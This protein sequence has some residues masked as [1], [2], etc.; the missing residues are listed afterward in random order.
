MTFDEVKKKY[1]IGSYDSVR[2]KYG[3]R[4]DEEKFY[5]EVSNEVQT[6]A[7]D[8]QNFWMNG[9]AIGTSDYSNLTIS[10]AKLD[11]RLKNLQKEY[12]GN[13]QATN[14]FAQLSDALTGMRNQEYDLHKANNYKKLFSE[15]QGVASTLDSY[16]TKVNNGE[17][18]SADDLSA[19]R[20]ASEEYSRIGDQLFTEEFGYTPEEIQGYKNSRSASSNLADSAYGIYR[21]YA[22][23]EAYNLERAWN[24]EHGT[25]GARQ[26]WNNDMLRKKERLGANMRREIDEAMQRGQSEMV[27]SIMDKYGAKIEA[28]DAELGKYERGEE[29]EYGL[30]Y[31]NKTLDEYY[32]LMGN[33]DFYI[34]SQRKSEA[35]NAPREDVL[36]VYNDLKAG[37]SGNADIW[38]AGTSN[39]W[40]SL[41]SDEVQLYYYIGNT[42]G[43]DKAE[44][45]LNNIVRTL[46][47]RATE[48]AKEEW[49]LAYDEAN[50]FGKAWMNIKTVPAN[51]LSGVI[52][53]IENVAS[54][55]GGRDIDPY[56]SGQRGMHYSNTV[57]SATESDL[58]ALTGDASLLGISLGDFYQAVMS[59]ADSMVSMALFGG[60]GGSVA[61]GMGAAQN[62]AYDLYKK[63]ASA[64]QILIGSLAAGAAEIAFEKIAFGKLKELD[65]VSGFGGWLKNMAVQGVNEFI[66][67][68]ETEIANII[69]DHFVMGT[70]SEVT[71][72]LEKNNGDWGQTGIDLLKQVYE[73]GVAGFIG[74]FGA[75]GVQSAKSQVR[76]NA[77]NRTIGKEIIKTGGV[78]TLKG[79]TAEGASS[80]RID[81]LSNKVTDVDSRSNARNVGQL[82]GEVTRS[83]AKKNA[84]ANAA[85]VAKALQ[86]GGISEKDASRLA[87]AIIAQQNGTATDR[88]ND[89]VDQ[90][91]ENDTV[92]KVMRDIVLN[93]ESSVGQRS[94]SIREFNDAVS[95]VKGLN[96]ALD[97]ADM[98]IVTGKL[99]DGGIETDKVNNVAAAL[100]A[101]HSGVATKEQKQ[102]LEE[103]KG[104]EAVANANQYLQDAAE[105][106]LTVDTYK[107]MLDRDGVVTGAEESAEYEELDAAAMTE[108]FTKAGIPAAT[109]QQLAESY[110]AESGVVSGAFAEDVRLAF[111]YGKLNFKEGLQNL[112][113]SES[114]A[115]EIF[116]MGAESVKVASTKLESTR[117]IIKDSNANKPIY[118]DNFTYN[119]HQLNPTQRA[120][121][122]AIQMINKLSNL[123]VH[124]YKSYKRDGKFY[125]TIN[126]EE[127]VAPNGYFTNGNQIHIDLN[128]GQVGEGTMLYTL[129]H[130]IGHYIAKWNAADFKAIS[131]F[132]FEHYAASTPVAELIEAKKEVVRK[133][134]KMDKK[135][136]P[137][138]AQL[139]QEAQEELVCDML[140]KVLADQHAYDVLMELKQKDLR[141][142]RKLGRAIK[143]ILQRLGKAIGVYQDQEPAA[144]YAASTKNFGEKAFR[145]LQELYV[146]A[147]EQ[148]DANYLES[149]TPGEEGTVFSEDGDP[150]AHATEDGTV[151]LSMRTYEEEGRKA[152][153][154]YLKKCVKNK[155][156]TDDEMQ[157]MMNGI[158][159]IYKT[160][161]EFKD[162]YAPFSTWSDASVVRDT[163]GKPV[164]SVVTPNGDYKM[165]L[166]F[167]LV[168]KKRRTLDAVFNEMARRGI[169]D[170]FELGQ[171]SVVK[172]NE[173]IRKYGLET[174]CALC[175]V[176]AKR[177]RQAS[178]AD[179]FVRLYNELVESLVPEDQRGNIE[180]FN[181]GG[182]DTIGKV[183]NGIHTWDKSKLDFTHLDNVMKNYEE[184]TVE[185]KA[186]KYIKSHAEGRKL[187]LR[188]DFMSSKG[189]DAV[190][191]QNP[192]VLKL[193]NSKKGTGGPKAA[194]GD[195]QYMNEIIEKARFWT[196]E[197]A[198]AVGGIR[199][200]SFSDYVPRMV[201]DYVQMV[202]DMAATKLPAHAYTKEA[203]FAKQFGLT[204]IK[205]NMSLIPAIAK[206]GIA[207][208]LDADGNYVWAGESFDFETAKQI[209]N[210][211]GYTENCGTIC[212]GVSYQHIL[213]LLSDPDIRMVI[214]YHKSGLNPIVAHMNQ[215][216]EFTDYTSLKTNPGG[217]QNTMNKNGSKVEVDFNFNKV[218]RETGDPKKT[219]RQYLDWCAEHEYTPRFAE[220]A[221]HENYYK[222]IED[223]TLYDK[224]GKYVPQRAVKAT[225][226][227][228]GNA[229]G[230]MKGLIQ[231]GLQ[232]DAVI[233]GKR[234]KNL[235]A[236]VNEIQQT[237]PKTE[238]E[239]SEEEVT[240]A[241]RD[242]EDGTVYSERD[243]V[244]YDRT[245]ILKESKV[246]EYLE[247]YA[248]VS[249]PKYAQAYITYMRPRTFLKL[250]TDD[251]LERIHISEQAGEL[252]E[253][254]LSNS[255]PG[256]YL[257]IDH[258]TGK[259]IGHEGRHRMAAME[260]AHINL[261]PVLLLDD[262]NKKTKTDIGQMYLHGQFDETE[263]GVVKDIIP[264]SY[265]NRDRIIKKFATQSTTQRIGE[266]Y[267][268][269]KTLRFQER[270]EGIASNR[271][272]LAGAL[273]TV[274]K[275]DT[276][277]KNLANYKKN[278]EMLNAEEEKL[279]GLQKELH[280]LMFAK[281][282]RN[283]QKMAE[284]REEIAK[285][286]NRINTYDGRL[287]RME[288][289][290]PLRNLLTRE[291]RKGYK[292]ASAEAVEKINEIRE[293]L[294]TKQMREKVMRVVKELDSMLK[295]DS[296]KRHVPDSLKK[297]VA[298]ALDILNLDTTN[299]DERVAMYRKW[300]AEETDPD[301]IDAYQVS[302]ENIIRAGEKMGE[303]LSQLHT[304]YQAIMT[305]EDKDI[306]AGYDPG[307]ALA[308]QEL[309]ETIGTTPINKLSIEQLEDVYNVYM[310][311][312]TR[313]RDANKSLIESIKENIK[314]R[315]LATINEVRA[316]GGVH[317]DRVSMLDGFKRFGWNNLKPVYA[318]EEIGS[319]TLT[320]AFNNVR[321]GEDT[322]ALDVTAARAYFLRL[323]KEYG[324]D[325]W[326]MD[327][328]YTFEAIDGQKFELTLEQM[329]SLYAYSKR[330]QADEHLRLGG[331]VFDSNIE[332]K[333]EKVKDEK[334]GEVVKKTV[335]KY[336][337]NTARSHQIGLD[338]MQ[339][340]VETV[341][342]I[343]GVKDFVDGMQ[344]YLSTTMGAK[345]NEVTMKMYGIKLFKEE[346]YFPLKSAKQ[347]LFEQNQV[348]GEV[349]IKNS[350]F[351]NKLVAGANNPIILSNFM[352][353]WCQ[354]VNDMSMYHAFTLPLEDFNRIFN[355]GSYGKEGVDSESVKGTIQDAYGPAAV[356]YIKQLI[357]DLNGG[358]VSDPREVTGQKL[359]GKWKKAKVMASL[360]VVIQQP[361]SIA[362][363]FAMVDPKYFVGKKTGM[364]EAESW[365]EL[366]KYAPVA[367]I[368]EMGYFDT[369]MGLGVKDFIQQKEYEGFKDKAKGVVT[370]SNYRD[371]VLGKAPAKADE[372]TWVAIWN[373]VKRETAGRHPD[374]KPGTEEY[375]KAAGERFTEVITKTQVY[376][377]VLARSANMR[378]KGTFMNMATAFLAEPTTTINMAID[379]IVKWN[380]GEKKLA[381][382][383]LR[384]V[385]VCNVINNMLSSLVY[386]MRDDDEEETFIE[387]YMQSLV[388]GLIDDMNPMTYFPWL[389][390]VWSIL[391][392]YDVN[393]SDMSLISDAFNAGK[394]LIR[395]Y[396]R[397]ENLFRAW[398]EL[399][400]S[401]G[402]FLGVPV[403]NMIREG[404]AFVNTWDTWTKDWGARD[405]TWGSLGDAIG[406]ALKN[407]A[408]VYG[409]FA[410]DSKT[411]D[412]YDAVV[413]G[414][415]K[416]LDRF[417]GSYVDKDGNFDESKYNTALKQGLR[418]NDERIRE[419]AEARIDGDY[420][421]YNQLL[422]EIKNEGKF[423]HST[424]RDAIFAE[425]NDI[426]K[427]NGEGEKEKSK[428]EAGYETSFTNDDYFSAV[429]AGDT[430]SAKMI[431]KDL[432]DSK[433]SDG[434]LNHEAADSISTALAT[435]IGNRYMDGEIS[436]NQA[437]KLLTDNTDKGETEAKK[438]DFEMKYGFSWSNRARKYRT[439]KI[440]R[441]D[442]EKWV[443]DIDG[444]DR[445]EAK[446]YVDFL[447]LEMANPNTDITAADAESFF[448]HAQ[449]SGIDIDTYLEFK[450]KVSTIKGD[451]KKEQVLKY[452]HSLPLTVAQKDALYYAQGYAESNVKNTPWH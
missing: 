336:K 348:S 124:V 65:D 4:S 229:F 134:Y 12:A 271:E 5:D 309:A 41:G 39:N 331:F 38:A 30:S 416:Y 42:K 385:M 201:F 255:R 14:Y 125:T 146:M 334:T 177:F 347:F 392:G 16:S 253:E 226:P 322:W 219:V 370:D 317:D 259:V 109:A 224:D 241:D 10:G 390:D 85:D 440:S 139:E 231:E 269:S 67:E 217:C 29:N 230:S 108:S 91:A 133:S 378:S 433:L 326:D 171:K 3:I 185:Y 196:P 265:E 37:R 93:Q 358:A 261:V 289:S 25:V 412:L 448:E 79:M 137:G 110:D 90:F 304:G 337:K 168:C 2:G 208:G 315:S 408:P 228:E 27:F 36:G 396:D 181:F 127:R 295:E 179:S 155:R 302:L 447:D 129:S 384:A 451:D 156:L 212:V 245:A 121:M 247:D 288:V 427:D 207:P 362:R 364:T 221:W 15:F 395:A 184:G 71:Q 19:Y 339:K 160:C 161:K 372:I 374:L 63:G 164:F 354:H 102:L 410:S 393:R 442:L 387:K 319:K 254:R 50:F 60:V 446:A 281:G 188:G 92:H 66:E 276:E 1:G 227:K 280:D 389:K 218:L 143:L 49:Q 400:G 170:D 449:P 320:E 369:G 431:Y 152:L 422:T 204:G 94:K 98:R 260:N 73:A 405:T 210:A 163:R 186:A 46:N 379:A 329:M 239:I 298:G 135:P 61:L 99:R 128:A 151:Q 78:E 130:E 401:V 51:V 399:S 267:G 361:T 220:F 333:K 413:S 23:E 198:Y 251:F 346:N 291:R 191:T 203:L 236:I 278:I 363:A 213:K 356:S 101:V 296:K 283:S 328:T 365:E 192:D 262:S 76:T 417:K 169:I 330:A 256:I 324:Y 279:T 223:F 24:K 371:E 131:D 11:Q 242:L 368:K 299:T 323:S 359:M 306:R 193:Y 338:T 300:I 84:N 22:N 381:V 345:G 48:K 20:A 397:D 357:T 6:Y 195:V 352:D 290:T 62:K 87:N 83:I 180:R 28:I 183:E 176:D 292:K 321:K 104:N 383:I 428:S 158:D 391:Q 107:A 414:D 123:E 294:S 44:D 343:E 89:F 234:E 81:N 415:Q 115:N 82:Y 286:T 100:A 147:F 75:G 194:F 360:S 26:K 118:Y 444:A 418:D 258:D 272:L 74:G 335:L 21:G 452:I 437:I 376:D 243:Y 136:I 211:E 132:L 252:D 77:Y 425:E 205:I 57:R 47:K 386:A 402:N 55:A 438:W 106:K 244:A 157:E 148:A 149:L 86:E 445:A 275:D 142:F 232:E 43:W 80:R 366:K 240:Q 380:R 403:E 237:I 140:S 159:D 202:Y 96:K 69:S 40:D 450:G 426:R 54:W 222:L 209:Q 120:S 233:E 150:V 443:M 268:I 325:N 388:S 112:R 250:T 411:D 264:L 206:G 235:P 311:V 58:N 97:A 432:M 257:R 439:G 175:F 70:Q 297:A 429:L 105:D 199:V 310:S 35:G 394:G 31:G 277:R 8:W 7:N 355:Y 424:I 116:N 165:N 225:F 314:E 174:A 173:I 305:S 154:K 189:F 246:D 377:S 351:T 34:N 398:L 301:K 144:W 216:A 382:K 117:K 172:I 9:G 248:A 287:L 353:V 122:E 341:S 344:D 153:E 350:G 293:K 342:G 282:P 103:F 423:S 406:D 308:I 141:L 404:Y 56:T 312:L 111:K 303:K 166:D 215:I 316:T 266:R 285:T 187:L 59:R 435:E 162:K 113:L 421:R 88:Q 32:G 313:V 263:M 375:L 167:S 327:K 284:L 430:E 178:M 307:I 145:E 18:M 119:K 45:F 419:A 68:A 318:F 214:P 190:K 273:E 114:Q 182:Y 367:I 434:Y 270:T 373:A 13:E 409:I 407:S 436:R 64:N 441:T 349:R 274:A 197:K 249:T 95:Y 52:G 72:L 53:T 332:F 420:K 126:G 138:D 238:A 200:Q 340:I 17:W 33:D